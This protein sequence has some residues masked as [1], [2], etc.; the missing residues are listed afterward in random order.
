VRRPN[1]GH[2]RKK[3][4]STEARETVRT[5]PSEK[6]HAIAYADRGI[7]RPER[8]GNELHG[9]RKRGG[10]GGLLQNQ[11]FYADSFIRK[12]KGNT[13]GKGKR[14]FEELARVKD[15]TRA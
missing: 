12:K 13:R 6:E 15:D 4:P 3:R 14:Y 10:K 1:G 9:L 7:S 5:H 11:R 2:Q 8:K